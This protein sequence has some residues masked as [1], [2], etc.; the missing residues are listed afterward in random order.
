MITEEEKKIRV[1]KYLLGD[2]VTVKG[3]SAN[4]INNFVTEIKAKLKEKEKWIKPKSFVN[5]NVKGLGKMLKEKNPPDLRAFDP[6]KCRIVNI[7]INDDGSGIVEGV[8]VDEHVDDWRLRK[9]YSFTIPSDEEL[10]MLE[11]KLLKEGK[12]KEVSERTLPIH[13][14]K[15]HWPEMNKKIQDKKII[16]RWF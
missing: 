9:T 1:E 11:E 3:L 14:K 15:Q 16:V 7:Q 4:K 13:K 10:A 12:L 6:D 5:K 2:S 8:V